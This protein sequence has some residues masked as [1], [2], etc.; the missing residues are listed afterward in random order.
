MTTDVLFCYDLELP[1][2]FSP[3]VVDGEVESF[4]LNSVDVVLED[5]VAARFKPNVAVVTIDFL[6]RRGLIAPELDGYLPL[7]GALRRGDC[8]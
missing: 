6:V 7:V 4:S 5:L 1:P 3:K 8:S 2:D